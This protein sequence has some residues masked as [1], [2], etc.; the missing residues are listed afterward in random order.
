LAG[1]QPSSSDLK[2]KKFA[3]AVEW[4][5]NMKLFQQFFQYISNQGWLF[6]HKT[7]RLTAS[8]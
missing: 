6:F 1:I 4:H 2:A 3:M 8:F 5:E 7:K